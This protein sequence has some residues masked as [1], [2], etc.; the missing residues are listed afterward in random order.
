M[1]LV[2]YERSDANSLIRIEQLI[3]VTP[4]KSNWGGELGWNP[5]TAD[6]FPGTAMIDRPYS[7]RRRTK[8]V[9]A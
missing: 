2:H 7:A 1:K 3:N 9:G 8:G 4:R 5:Q 6:E